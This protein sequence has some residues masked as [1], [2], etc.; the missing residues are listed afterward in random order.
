MGIV[1]SFN[2]W[3]HYLDG[4]ANIEVYTDHQNLKDFMSQSRLNGRQTRWLIKLLPYYFHLFYRKGALNPADGPSRRPDY[5]DN[6]EADDLSVTH[7]LPILRSRVR[8]T[9]PSVGSTEEPE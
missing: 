6:D 9:E 2:H 5:F 3:R 8:N 7:L 4:A 1:K